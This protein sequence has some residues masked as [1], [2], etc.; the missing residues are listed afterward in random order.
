MWQ[1]SGLIGLSKMVSLPGKVVKKTKVSILWDF[2]SFY[3]RPPTQA[4]NFRIGYIF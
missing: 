3:Q 4:F 2:L 1:Q